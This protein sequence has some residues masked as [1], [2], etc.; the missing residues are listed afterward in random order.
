M[1]GGG[2]RRPIPQA[3]DRAL[4]GPI[5][6]RILKIVHQGLQNRLPEQNRLMKFMSSMQLTRQI[7]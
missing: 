3:I 4:A 7:I 1:V 6:P 5:G 2:F